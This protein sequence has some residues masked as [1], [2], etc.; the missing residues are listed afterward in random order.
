MDQY[1]RA[2]GIKNDIEKVNIASVYLTSLALLWWRRTD[3][4]EEEVETLKLGS[5]ISTIEVKKGQKKKGLMFVDISIKGKKLSALVDTG[6]S[7]LFMPDQVA[8]RLTL[9][10]DLANGFIKTV[11]A[12]KAPITEI[13]K[14]VELNIGSCTDYRALN[15]FTVKNKYPIPLIADLFDQL[16][17]ARWF[18]KIN[19]RS[20]YYQGRIAE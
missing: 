5:I 7:E 4:E 14:G 3:E 13:S 12:K 2:M 11:N 19:L 20:R 10:I 17:D 18:T 8:S 6:A 16:G 15:K 1:F 9:Q